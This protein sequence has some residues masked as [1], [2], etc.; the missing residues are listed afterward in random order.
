LTLVFFGA[1]RQY[2]G[3]RHLGRIIGAAQA[4]TVLASAVG[5]LVFASCSDYYGSYRPALWTVA[6]ASLLVA[7]WAL[8]VRG[9]G[10]YTHSIE[11]QRNG[12]NA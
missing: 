5:P 11:Q 4:G 7:A 12:S 8:A 2:F 9:V 10:A 1:W 6:G 3:E